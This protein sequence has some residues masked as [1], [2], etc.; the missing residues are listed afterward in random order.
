MQLHVADDGNLTSK[1]GKLELAGLFVEQR[2][3]K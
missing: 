1:Y 2:G 3:N